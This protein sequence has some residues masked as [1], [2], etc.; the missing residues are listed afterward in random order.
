MRREKIFEKYPV[1]RES[2]VLTE[3]RDR[4]LYII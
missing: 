4:N 1:K 2:A 3:V